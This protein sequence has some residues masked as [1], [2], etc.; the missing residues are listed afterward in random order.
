MTLDSLHSRRKAYPFF[1]A[2]ACILPLLLHSG[3]FQPVLLRFR[4]AA[5]FIGLTVAFFYVTLKLREPRWNREQEEHVRAQIRSSLINLIPEDLKVTEE[6][7]KQLE[8]AEIYKTLSG[9]FWDTINQDELLR[10]QK[11]QFYS[12]GLDYST[13]IDVFLLLRFLGF[14][15]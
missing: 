3:G 10:T 6:E 14:V 15:I 12:N 11:E 7:K 2:I 4:L 8:S 13:A 5:C 9:I 1:I